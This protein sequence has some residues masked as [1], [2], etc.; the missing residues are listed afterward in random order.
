[1]IWIFIRGEGRLRYEIRKG[2]AAGSYEI[3]VTRPGGKPQVERFDDPSA[4]I[5]R[6]LVL[7]QSLLD[8]GWRLAQQA[9]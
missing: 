5:E 1:M 8:E 6:S 4:L 7:Q 9:G 3:S 2:G